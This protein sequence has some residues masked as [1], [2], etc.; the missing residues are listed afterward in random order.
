MKRQLL[1]VCLLLPLSLHAQ[2]LQL[3]GDNCNISYL[4]M[5]DGLLHNY[6]DDIYKDSRGFIWLSTGGG[7]SRYDGFSFTNYQME[8]SPVTLKGNSVHRV[9]EDNFNRL[10]IASD[11]GL[12]ILDL[13]NSEL[14]NLFEEI[15][16]EMT[17]FLKNPVKNIIK[18]NRVYI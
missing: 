17:A 3:S 2:H 5:E 6:I 16:P 15:D 7:L 10:W 9:Y 12:D 8:T 18:D 1:S 13:E 14:V 4:T 11:G